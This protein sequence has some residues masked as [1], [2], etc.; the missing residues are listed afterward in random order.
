MITVGLYIITSEHQLLTAYE[1]KVGPWENS[2][3]LYGSNKTELSSNL[4]SI[5]DESSVFKIHFYKPSRMGL[6]LLLL[7]TN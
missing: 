3:F 1:V 7:F 2:A 4:Q 5:I 6:L